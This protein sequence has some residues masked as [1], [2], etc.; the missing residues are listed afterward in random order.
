M[1]AVWIAIDPG[2][3]PRMLGLLPEILDADDKRPVKDQ[4]DDRYAHGGGWRPFPE[5]HFK[6][7]RMSMTLR[8]PGDP[9]FRP[10]A[11]TQLGDETVVFYPSCSL[12]AV[13]QPDGKYEVTRVD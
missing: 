10:A 3:D 12:L 4:L 11:F 8:F 5:N 2:F 7:E 1:S 9:P 13:I 6:L